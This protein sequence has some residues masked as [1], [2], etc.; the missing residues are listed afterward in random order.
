MRRMPADE[1]PE[2]DALVAGDHGVALLR[3]CAVWRG[4]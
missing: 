2:E 3:G 4:C 1:D